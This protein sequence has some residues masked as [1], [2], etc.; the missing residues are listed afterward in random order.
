MG[1]TVSIVMPVL[2]ECERIERALNHLASIPDLVEVVVVDGGSV[3]G[4]TDIVKKYPSVTLVEAPRGRAKQMNAGAHRAT[5]DVLLFLHAD[6][7][8]PV[9]VTDHIQAALAEPNTVAGAFLTWTVPDGA[10]LFWSPLLH[11]ADLR[12]RYTPYPYGDQAIFVRKSVF[13]QMHGFREMDLMEDLDFS[14]RLR[15]FGKIVRV[16]QRVLVSGRRFIANPVRY[17]FLV[18]V[19]PALYLLGVPPKYLSALYKPVR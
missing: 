3:D 8:I 18:N 9:D 19:L 4:T 7:T 15:T 6:V 5:G 14:R 13:H 10:K 17:T 2:N 11:L 16:K 12:S 1:L